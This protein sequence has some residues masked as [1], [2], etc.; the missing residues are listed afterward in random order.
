MNGKKDNARRKKK[1]GNGKTHSD[2]RTRLPDRSEEVI[3][4]DSDDSNCATD[5]QSIDI[6]TEKGSS[7]LG[8][9]NTAPVCSCDT[10][11]GL[12]KISGIPVESSTITQ[13]QEAVA[14]DNE[15][16]SELQNENPCSDNV[17]SRTDILLTTEIP[18]AE[19]DSTSSSDDQEDLK[20]SSPLQSSKII[21][22]ES[23][24]SSPVASELEQED[25]DTGN[26]GNFVP[27][28]R[29][30]EFSA[31]GDTDGG[32]RGMQPDPG[33]SSDVNAIACD[34][35]VPSPKP[36]SEDDDR[37]DEERERDDE[38]HKK[39]T[40]RTSP[41]LSL[42]ER[43]IRNRRRMKEKSSHNGSSRQ[44]ER[45]A[46]GSGSEEENN[47]DWSSVKRGDSNST[48]NQS[49]FHSYR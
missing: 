42:T 10:N 47:D 23:S 45:N 29:E 31:D 7:E 37:E 26:D 38:E 32:S 5:G 39:S 4:L 11:P 3:T 2:K 22:R 1:S 20:H 13:D 40:K 8:S 17:G 25:E 18:H 33:T 21:S 34:E 35:N 49:S 43:L 36:S 19:S 24:C 16:S 6:I 41:C 30:E 15:H 12:D 14:Q 46:S 27:E 9:H 48:I 28:D 44:K